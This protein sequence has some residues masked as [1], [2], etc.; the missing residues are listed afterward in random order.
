MANELK[1][2]NPND[3]IEQPLDLKK[4]IIELTE[5]LKNDK[6]VYESLKPLG[7]TNKEVRENIGKLA[8]YQADFNVCKK[9]PGFDKCP[10]QM[11]HVSMYVYKDGDYIT[12]R[13]EPC[14]KY[15]EEME[16]DSKYVA[17]DFPPEWKKSKLKKLD[18]SN[19]RK[20]LIKDFI[21]IAN[22][23]SHKWLFVKG[24][25]KVGKSFVLVT[26]ANEFIALGLGQVAVINA[27]KQ[28]KAI[29]DN[30]YSNKELFAKSI[31]I[32][33]NVPLLVIDDFGQEYKNELI[34]DQVVIPILN[35]RSH[36]DKP[37]FFS[38]E[39]TISEI[40]KLYSIGKNGGDIRGK[41]LGNLL[42]EMCGEEYDLTGVSIYKKK[43]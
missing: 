27:A 37:T 9:C 5:A 4:Y 12:T 7:L 15:I 16:L 31:K 8:D 13:S 19:N 11:R 10:K 35:E 20:P 39:F 25:H 24:N 21:E 17:K 28:F 3:I 1:E 29:A 23:H 42:H 18:L 33:S 6:D 22:G 41:Q 38:S 32:L 30:A 2:F 43:K 34:R 14:K 36:T 26:F 40:Q